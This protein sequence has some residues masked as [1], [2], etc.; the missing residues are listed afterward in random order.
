MTPVAVKWVWQSHGVMLD[1]PVVG[2]IYPQP[3]VS[4]NWLVNCC[5][6]DTQVQVGKRHWR[7]VKTNGTRSQVNH[8]SSEHFQ[9]T[10][11]RHRRPCKLAQG[12][13]CS[14]HDGGSDG[15]SYCE[16]KKYM[17]LKFYT[18]QKNLA[19]KF[20][21]PKNTRLIILNTDLFNQTDFKT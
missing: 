2:T 16:P 1:L 15:A 3:W 13:T 11:A 19:S 14:I 20:S 5:L 17:S 4:M 21:S 6:L 10:A 7:P 9:L 18:P 12:C 8:W